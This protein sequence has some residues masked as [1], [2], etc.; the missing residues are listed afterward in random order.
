MPAVSV[1]IPSYNHALYLRECIES[2]IW[3]SFQD[4]ELIVVD[5]NS[6]D[7]SLEIARRFTDPRIRVIA[8]ETNLG[9]YA[10]QNVGVDASRGEWVA[11]LNSDD[12]WLPKKLESQ[13]ALLG[14]HSD[15]LFAYTGS[16]LVTEEGDPVH[17][18]GEFHGDYPRDA[19]QNLLPYLLFE[20]RVLASSVLFKRG[21]VRFNPN[22][23][24]SGDWIALLELSTQSACAY[25]DQP[26]TVW[27][28]HPENSYTKLLKVIPEEIAVREAILCRADEWLAHS[29]N[30]SLKLSMCGVALSA[31]YVRTGQMIR[32][33]QAARLA[34]KLDPQNP[35]ARALRVLSLLPGAVG[36]R[37]LWK[38][39]RR[40]RVDSG[41]R[42]EQVFLSSTPR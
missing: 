8:N 36:R 4:W 5:D 22:L 16:K 25:V 7:E 42:P 27:R 1:V 20:N 30:A 21:A 11:I 3:Q 39:A 32:A 29:P 17:D 34:R 19:R 15:C 23:R 14:E 26:L 35:R 40:V 13:L 37:K 33:R 18:S 28:Q 24:C 31:L 12:I 2:V 10:T 9:T 6:S 41:V 38:S